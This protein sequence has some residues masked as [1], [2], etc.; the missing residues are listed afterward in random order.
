MNLLDNN[1]VLDEALAA[2]W[3]SNGTFNYVSHI[4][5]AIRNTGDTILRDQQCLQYFV[6]PVHANHLKCADYVYRY[7]VDSN[8]TYLNI[9]AGCGYVEKVFKDHGHNGIK[10]CDW[11]PTDWYFDYWRRYFGVEDKLTHDSGDLLNTEWEI[12]NRENG[13]ILDV[14]FDSIIALRFNGWWRSE[15]TWKAHPRPFEEVLQFFRAAK[16]YA[17]EM[18]VLILGLDSPEKFTDES[19]NWILDNTIEKYKNGSPHFWATISLDNV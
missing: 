17:P 12:R 3:I 8:K 11:Q 10:G 7:Y 1:G 6:P 14:K 19:R 18:F 5:S 15:D 16:K 13:N 4:Q 9:G 2:G